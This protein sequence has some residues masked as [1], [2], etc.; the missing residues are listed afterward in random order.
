MP[1]QIKENA[2]T[3]VWYQCIFLIVRS[4]SRTSVHVE[5]LGEWNGDR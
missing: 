1:L 5:E 4:I 2:L 3:P